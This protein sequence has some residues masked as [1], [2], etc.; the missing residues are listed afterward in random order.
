M[1]AD[2]GCLRMSSVEAD[3]LPATGSLSTTL[4][5]GLRFSPLLTT[6]KSEDRLPVSLLSAAGDGRLT[7]AA[8]RRRLSPPV[9]DLNTPATFTPTYSC[10]HFVFD[11]VGDFALTTVD[12]LPA[13]GQ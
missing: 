13:G 10:G 9:D 3:A 7:T 2:D 6:T 4:S 5:P 12:E 8:L 1:P 11:G